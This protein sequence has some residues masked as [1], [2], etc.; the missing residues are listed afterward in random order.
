MALTIE[1]A[2]AWT[3]EKAKQTKQAEGKKENEQVTRPLP[4]PWPEAVRPV[5]NWFLRS[6]LFAAL[7][8]GQ[9]PNMSNQVIAAANGIEILFTGERFDQGELE[10]FENLLHL[11]RTQN[12]GSVCRFTAYGLLKMQGLPDSGKN[13]ETLGERIARLVTGTLTIRQGCRKY[14]GHLVSFAAKDEI[15]REWAV[16]LDPNLCHLFEK[17][18]FSQVGW[19]VRQELARHPLAQWLHG[20][21][22]SHAKPHPMRMETLL[23]L[24]GSQAASPRSANQT[25]RKALAALAVAASKH[26]EKFEFEVRDGLVHVT[27]KPSQTQR[28]HLAKKIAAQAAKAASSRS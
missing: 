22:S 4:R 19:A 18:Q 13:R 15:T 28:R 5:P 24:S 10:V 3:S 20:F 8:M 9:R 14:I 21:F 1:E 17:D 11:S 25:L 12:L 2:I 23:T 6:A 16:Q 26:G 7:P 27:R